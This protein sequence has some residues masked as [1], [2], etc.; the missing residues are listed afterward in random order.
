MFALRRTDVAERR[1]PAPLV[2][3]HL[4]IL[5]HFPLGVAAALEAIGQLDLQR[6]EERFCREGGGLTRGREPALC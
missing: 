5:E 4:D 3:E 6:G 2:V 1:V